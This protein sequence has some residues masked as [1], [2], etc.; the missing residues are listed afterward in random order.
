[1]HDMQTFGFDGR[2]SNIKMEN[3]SNKSMIL[4][5]YNFDNF[6]QIECMVNKVK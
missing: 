6:S 5:L 1:M 3:R 4:I 2:V